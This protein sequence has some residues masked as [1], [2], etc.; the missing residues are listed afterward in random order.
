[1]SDAQ[2]KINALWNS[3][4]E[5]YDVTPRH[6]ISDPRE[7]RAWKDALRTLLTPPARDVLDVGCGTGF[8]TLLLAD[9]GYRVRGVDLAEEMLARA[10]EKAKDLQVEIAFELGDAI[11]PPGTPQS[12]DVIVNRHLFWTLTDPS[13]ALEN[14]FRLLKPG[15]LLMFIDGL[16]GKK[17]PDPRLGDLAAALPIVSVSSLEAI[18]DLVSNAGFIAVAI[19]PLPEIERVELELHGRSEDEPRY[20]LTAKK[21]AT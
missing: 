17:E 12:V 5:T 18:R 9:M 13:R 20:A 21:P 2:H 14:W 16:W 1:M 8:L 7:E 4:A 10:Q 15:G 11:S 19:V 6:G 3:A